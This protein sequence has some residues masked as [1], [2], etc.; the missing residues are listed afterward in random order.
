M[1]TLK[2]LLMLFVLQIFSGQVVV[3]AETIYAKDGE[4]IQANISEKTED[5]IWYETTVGDITEYVGIDIADVEKVLDDEGN[6]SEY[7]P[8][9]IEPIV[10]QD[11]N[12]PAEA[13]GTE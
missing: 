4:V 7:D 6:I 2:I 13:G 9:F 3:Y 11:E 1:K 5:T 10:E 8:T 12:I